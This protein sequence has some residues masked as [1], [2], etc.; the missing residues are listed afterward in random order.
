MNLF[1]MLFKRNELKEIPRH[2]MITVEVGGKKVPLVQSD[3][4][5]MVIEN[6]I[7]VIRVKETKKQKVKKATD[8]KKYA[9]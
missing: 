5:E 6:G 3:N 1:K 7:A 2:K 9:L 8:K 4:L